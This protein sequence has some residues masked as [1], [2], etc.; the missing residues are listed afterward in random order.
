MLNFGEYQVISTL[1]EGTETI[2]QRVQRLT[3]RQPIILKMLKT[4]YPSFKAIAELKHEFN[5][6]KHLEHPHLVKAIHLKIF[7]QRL[8]LFLEDFGGESLAQVL[9]RE[10]LSP[11][12]CLSIGIQLAK[13]LKYLHQHHIIHKD[14]K[15]SNIIINVQTGLVKLTDFGIASHLSKETLPLHHPNSLAGTFTY[16]SPEQ[17]GRM[18][19]SLDYRSDFYSLGVSLYEMLAGRLPFISNDPLELVYFH[20]ASQ[21]INPREINPEIPQA[22][23]SIILKLMAKN[24]EER[25]QSATGLLTDLE[26]CFKQLQKQGKITNFVPGQIDRSGQL[27]IP[28]K[29]YG[30]EAEVA[31]LLTAFERI[32][33][34]P[35]EMMLVSG[36]SGIGKSAVVH[37]VHK[38]ITQ[39]KG[40]FISGKFD[41]F[42][43]N[44]PYSSLIQAFQSLMQQLL[45]ESQEKLQN[46]KEKLLKALENNG[47]LVIEVLPELEL[48]IG[49][50][51]AVAELAPTEAQNRFNRVF[52]QFIHVFTQKE[53]PL[54][55]FLDDLQWAD[56]ATLKILQLLMGD[57]DSKYLL[58]IGAYR[59]NE[60]SPEHLLNQTLEALQKSGIFVSNILLKPL[61]LKQVIQ[62][63]TETLQG[64]KQVEPIGE[65]IWNKTGGNPFF[66]T[67]LLSALYQENLLKF[68]FKNTC[69]KWNLEE[70][71]AIGITDKSVVE[72]IVSRIQKLPKATQNILKLAA[73]VGARFTLDI[74]SIVNETS[75]SVTANQLWD[76][77]QAGLILP[78]SEAYRIPLNFHPEQEEVIPLTFDPKR[79]GYKFLHDR[80]QQAAYSLIPDEEKQATHFKIGQLLL[81][82]IPPEQLE[83]NIFD[84]VNQLNAGINKLNLQ[85]KK[86]ELIRLNLSAGRKAKAAT[87]YEPA[88]KYFKVG[89]SLLSPD[90]WVDCYH[91]TLQLFVEAVEVEYLSANFEQAESLAEIVLEKAKTLLDC[92]KIYELK[93]QFNQAQS[94]MLKAVNTGLQVLALLGVDLLN[95]ESARQAALQLPQIEDIESIPVMTEPLPQAALR[96]LMALY[97]PAYIAK[98][99]IL[100]Q[101]ISTMV[102]LCLEHG[103]CGLAAFPY[104]LYGMILCGVKGDIEQGYYAGLLALKLL[105]QFSAKEQ[106][107]RVYVMFNGHIRIWKE[108]AKNTLPAFL[109]GF[110]SGLETGD[111]EWAIYNAKHYCTNLFLTGEP[112]D[113]VERQQK[114]YIKFIQKNK[115]DFAEYYAKIWQQATLNLAGK[116]TDKIQL[117][118]ENFNEAA[119]LERWQQ[120][121]NQMSLFAA[122]VAKLMLLYLFREYDLAVVNAELAT[123]YSE[124]AIGL[125]TVGIHNFYYSLSL[126]AHY[127]DTE[128]KEQYLAIVE[129]NQK[130]LK[131]WAESSPE[132]YQ[133]RYY[134]VAA[135][136]ARILGNKLEAMDYYDL[137]IQQAASNA[138][139]PEEALANERAAEFYFALGKNKIAK[140]YLTE[141]YYAYIHWGATAK[142]NDLEFQY[143]YLKVQA[144]P[145]RN[146]ESDRR[147]TSTTAHNTFLLDMSTVVR[148][149]QSLSEEIVL[150][151]LLE[152]LMHLVKENAGAQKVFFIAKSAENLVI[153]ASLT[154]TESITIL[155]S[156]PLTECE[157]LPISLIHY[158]ERTRT[159][160]VLDNA[161]QVQQFNA[162]P[163]IK[164]N[165][166]LSVLVSPIIHQGNLTGILYLE[167]N[168]TRGA[169]TKERLEVLGLL[170]AQAAISLEN[171]RFYTTLE[172]RVSQRTQELQNTLEELRRTQLQLIQS[173]KMSSLGQLVGG[174][175]HEI[176]NPINFIY[177]NLHH[178]SEYAKML[179]DLIELYQKHYQNPVEE[180]VAHSEEIELDFLKVDMQKMLDS[181]RL[182]AAR[183]RDMVLSLRSF[184][185]LD[186]SELKA[187]NLHEGLDSTLMILHQKLNQIQVIKNYGN[188]PLVN[189]YAGDLNQAFM[190]ILTNAIDIL[191]QG[192]GHQVSL[193]QNPTIWIRTELRKNDQ[194]AICIA[195][196][197]KG[198]TPEIAAKIFDPFFTTKPIGKGTGLGLAISYQIVV[199]QH[200]GQLL[201][202]SKPE[203][204]TEL[205]ILLPC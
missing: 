47:Q 91:L 1:Y 115:H 134:L 203:E 121:N 16:M 179:I 190:N 120:E 72:L 9:S 84:I 22:V 99:E 103:H 157:L 199:E 127:P 132:N 177:G 104:T 32:S 59:D 175:A 159:S 105:E 31:Q 24:A 136:K 94:Q 118:S 56:S 6:S 205:T 78:L 66:V 76:A 145:T 174:V 138:S 202:E 62:L 3:D 108:N 116:A 131:K 113:S 125:I 96:I 166:P 36:Y 153:E 23:A 117:N 85:Q 201:C 107:A 55:I 50:Q 130:I 58:L 20:M 18:N 46:W 29:L 128:A 27:M 26:L 81:Q 144:L 70:I 39:H 186:E 165:Q 147:V 41:Q 102:N 167:N 184:S 82:H 28:Q 183:I 160:L 68:D 158:V 170:S 196:N 42:K 139:L 4:E 197:G 142:V 171:A 93:I 61:N 83:D 75:P 7:N 37:E 198:M 192:V 13:A 124:A 53:H 204:G 11:L 5:I 200:R 106:K 8:G 74:L 119:M 189:C 90:S 87:A 64:S 126:L 92:V 191:S 98:P 25:Y 30:R 79:V 57:K 54:V 156:I 110:K 143:P 43:R 33:Q 185:R 178:T 80:V 67:Q 150:S 148:A 52:R 10:T 12:A 86:D 45:T 188:L 149:S 65:L 146:R 63:V 122:Y 155:Q 111:L 109:E 180:I 187:V 182:G 193:T 152:K 164:K 2:V 89:L 48:I 169:F 60:V 40:Y 141:A 21:P 97:P 51:P 77:L 137:A 154:G 71:Q 100:P 123:K 194:V 15:P 38:P 88:T 112:L 14:I 129:Q 49:Q 163:Y 101:V 35:S 181:M 151:N 44:I 161:T 162:D 114:T 133:Q 176:N 135:E 168:L 173:E 19:R 95:S 172:T 140:L 73:C 34:G 17:T 195:D 69:W